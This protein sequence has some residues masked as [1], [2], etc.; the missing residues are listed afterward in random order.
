MKIFAFILI[1]IFI[2]TILFS[3]TTITGGYISGSW[4][5][6]GSPYLI[7]DDITIHADS[8]LAIDPGVEIIYQGHYKFI[9]D[10]VMNAVGTEADSILFTA[11]DPDSGWRGLRFMTSAD[12][13]HLSYCIVEYGR[14]T[15]GISF[16]ERRGGGIYSYNSYPEISNCTIRNNKAG[17]YGGGI[18]FWGV[19]SSRPVIITDCLIMNNESIYD[20]GGGIYFN[21]YNHVELENC[22]INQN[23]ALQDGGGIYFNAS[24]NFELYLR[25]CTVEGNI[26]GSKGGGICN[27]GSP[28]DAQMY[29]SDCRINNNTS[30]NDG[31]G[32]WTDHENGLLDI[33]NTIFDGNSATGTTSNGG[34][35]YAAMSW[36][37]I[38]HV[39]F[40]NND[41]NEGGAIY[42]FNDASPEFD[43]CTIVNNT[44]VTG[45]GMFID[46]TCDIDLSNSIL[47]LNS[48]S[49]IHNEGTINTLEYSDF[50]YNSDDITGNIPLGFSELSTVNVNG[51]SCDVHLNIFMDPLLVGVDDYHLT[52]GSP[53]IDAGDPASPLD[54][55]GTRADMGA[56]YFNQVVALDP[57]QD[58]TI[59]IIGST[60]HL[61]WNA[62]AGAG[63]Y[64]I[65]S[66]DEPYTG[67]VDDTLGT[68]VGESWNTSIVNEKKFYYVIAIE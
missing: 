60:V 43:H 3:Q 16:H 65:Y 67:F 33:C 31:G 34:G 57:P 35:I 63:S 24:F 29:I 55:D 40:T 26:A 41:A 28:Q 66:S 30:A 14:A 2:S 68:F 50:F 7:E 54:P 58:V 37:T 8:I 64:K 23:N 12:T 17:A 46:E 59:E 5:E 36:S 39:T 6:V 48:T 21:G 13:S 10:G 9:V 38:E 27:I 52:S 32:I 11:A 18:C 4:T 20:R 49:A 22:S 61:S 25:N 15:S 42:L 47:S 51:D 45:S 1:F 53:C 19:G 56:F 44:A 62:V